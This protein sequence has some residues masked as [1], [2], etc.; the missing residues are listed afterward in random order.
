MK[1]HKACLGIFLG[2]LSYLLVFVLEYQAAGDVFSVFQEASC[3][4]MFLVLSIFA[5]RVW[6]I[7]ALPVKDVVMIGLLMVVHLGIMHS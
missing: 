5:I 1:K 7:G 3:F 4:A 6:R 2:A